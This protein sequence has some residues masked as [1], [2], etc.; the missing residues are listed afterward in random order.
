MSL[1]F[2]SNNNYSVEIITES[3]L[4]NI[5]SSN[6]P[7]EGIEFSATTNTPFVTLKIIPT[8]S[9][10]QPVLASNIKIDDIIPD[11]AWNAGVNYNTNGI[12]MPPPTPHGANSSLQHVTGIGVT[13]NCQTLGFTGF[14]GNSNEGQQGPYSAQN[15]PVVQAN[16]IANNSVSWSEIILIEVYEDDNGNL[17]N[18]NHSPATIENYNEWAMWV[19]PTQTPIVD[20]PYPVHVKAFVYLSFGTGGPSALTSNVTL[21]LDF[22]EVP[23]TFGCTN[24]T[25]TNYDSTATVDDGSCIVPVYGCTDPLALNYEPLATIDDGSCTYPVFG[26]NMSGLLFTYGPQGTAF[27]GQGTPNISTFLDTGYPNNPG[28][29]AAMM[30]FEITIPPAL[31]PLP[32]SSGVVYEILSITKTEVISPPGPSNPTG[33]FGSLTDVEKTTNMGI[34]TPPYG[35]SPIPPI[36]F[37]YYFSS[38]SNIVTI[39]PSGTPMNVTASVL[40]GAPVVIDGI[41]MPHDLNNIGS[42][43]YYVQ[44]AIR[45]TD[46]GA[47]TSNFSLSTTIT[48]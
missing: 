22:D 46:S 32:N 34:M 37:S 10:S 15:D 14:N 20:D 21:N 44:I 8:N 28:Q 31:N 45:M 40:L 1:T 48:L 7:G 12:C 6:G 17:I 19:G 27:Q 43:Q 4:G 35:V 41:I 26:P 23:P 5:S 9:Q 11:F 47:I 3:N 18:D 36:N 24:S 25:A 13:S 30:K 29:I 42:F 2:N 38:P 39:V 16:Q 33:T